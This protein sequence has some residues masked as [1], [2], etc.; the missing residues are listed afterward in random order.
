MRQ[1]ILKRYVISF[2]L[3][4]VLIIF[5]FSILAEAKKPASLPKTMIWT[6]Y[7]VGSSGYVQASAIADAFLKILGQRLGYYLQVQE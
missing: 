7:D 6:C 2:A 1:S 5:G 3:I 4:F